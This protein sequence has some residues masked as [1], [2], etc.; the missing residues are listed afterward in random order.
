MD[1]RG[2]T[3]AFYHVY[4]CYGIKDTQRTLLSLYNRMKHGISK[5]SRT[6]RCP[7]K[8]NMPQALRLQL[9]LIQL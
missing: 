9:L 4:M 6:P 7:R 8:P 5:L 1:G 3:E 2:W